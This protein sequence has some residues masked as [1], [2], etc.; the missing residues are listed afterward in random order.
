MPNTLTS[1]IPTLYEA[2]RIVSRELV[3]FIPTVA[4]DSGVERAA[5]GQSV[6]FHNVP[7][8]TAEDIVAAATGPDPAGINVG[9]DTMTISKSRGVP[10]YWTG[11]EQRG[12]ELS[13][14]RQNVMT[15]EFAQAMRTLVNEVEGDLSG[16]Y[17]GS[18]RAY[19]VA[20]TAPFGT[21]LAD[22]A[23]LKKILDD[24][25][26][27]QGDRSLVI[28]TRAGVN[29]RT[30][31]QLTKANE[32]GAD[33]TLR[34]GILLDLHNFGIRESA[35][36]KAHSAGT[37]S[38][39]TLGGAHAAGDTVITTAATPGTGTI[40]VGDVVEI[41]NHKYVV[42]G[43]LPAPG[44]D[45]E[46]AAPGLRENL[47]DAEAITVSADFTANMAFHRNAFQLVT[48]APAMPEGGDAADDVMEI[49]DPVS[50]LGFQVALYRQRR[51]VAYEVGLAWGF[52][53]VQ[54]EH[55][56]LLLG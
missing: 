20:G 50:G 39:Y 36:I 40:L 33:D 54:P 11:E 35:Q 14:Q 28:D 46:I 26:T 32:A 22:T 27:P 49:Q 3:G 15:Q 25:G 10:F 43:A 19:G 56:A 42:T 6:S 37:G 51:R 47:P 13:G 23:W 17:L 48:R 7:T 2:L 29:L 21:N 5:V 30:L 9:S 55:A 53:A 41:G 45:F 8:M 18:S 34:R 12:V 24:N 1:L 4:R 52:K 31:A 44:G 16:L 38:G